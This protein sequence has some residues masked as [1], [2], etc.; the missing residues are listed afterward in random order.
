[1]QRRHLGARVVVLGLQY[2]GRS[3]RRRD[4]RLLVVRGRASRHPP[5]REPFLVRL[6]QRS[7]HLA[8]A[9]SL[10]TEKRKFR[11]DHPDMGPCV[12]HRH[13]SRRNVTALLGSIKA[14]RSARCVVW[15]GSTPGDRAPGGRLNFTE[16][17]ISKL[18]RVNSTYWGPFMRRLL[19]AA[20]LA[21]TVAFA[22]TMSLPA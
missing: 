12:R 15:T 2:C 21:A 8:H 4:A 16:P 11:R 9:P 17:P 5:P 10:L 18:A 22:A 1:T 20:T 13:P 7:A 14:T 19:A 3:H 6:L